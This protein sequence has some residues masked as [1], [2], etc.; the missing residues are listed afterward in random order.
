MPYPGD[1]ST[2]S[3]YGP[4]QS[5]TTQLGFA[6]RITAT[7]NDS[8]DPASGLKVGYAWA[9]LE[10]E[11]NRSQSYAITDPPGDSNQWQGVNA[12]D[13]WNRIDLPIGTQCWAE[14]DA[15]GL[16]WIIQ[17]GSGFAPPVPDPSASPPISADCSNAVTPVTSNCSAGGRTLTVNSLTVAT[18]SSGTLVLQAC[19][20]STISLGPCSPYAPS[21]YPTSV[22]T[23]V[24]PTYS[25]PVATSAST[26]TVPAE[27]RTVAVSPAANTTLTLP[28]WRAADEF[29]ILKAN[30]LATWS[31]TVQK[32]GADTI[33]GGTSVVLPKEAQLGAGFL[34]TDGG[35]SGAWIATPI[36]FLDGG[37]A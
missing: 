34:M 36:G 27:S 22:V 26:Y 25:P 33:N 37:S 9:R 12:F 2:D 23:Q 19:T 21:G 14:P 13:I 3:P 8:I 5:R 18:N 11:P 17:G 4:F 15:D 31:I 10:L 16:G 7:Y 29:Q 28:A 32:A 24:C 30:A 6:V 20:P 35:T 1:Y